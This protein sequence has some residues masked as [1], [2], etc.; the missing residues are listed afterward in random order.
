M[1]NDLQIAMQET[2]LDCCVR[3]EKIEALKINR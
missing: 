3:L 2:V 1:D